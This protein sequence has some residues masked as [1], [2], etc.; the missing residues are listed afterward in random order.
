[1][2]YGNFVAYYRVSTE[3]QGR[4][5]LG[6]DAQR[7]AVIG[8][9]NGGEWKMVAEFVEVESGKRSDNRPQLEAA[10]TAARIRNATLII[11]KLDRLS[12]D[13]HFLLGL[14]K[15]GVDFVAA[16]MPTANKMMVGF[17]ALIAQ[18]EREMISKRTKDAL[19]A[20]KARGKKLGGNPASLKNRDIGS[21]RGNETK[22]AKA[23]GRAVDL[24]PQIDDIRQ[25]GHTSLRQIANALN[26]RGIV[27]PRGGQWTA[28]QVRILLQRLDTAMPAQE[29]A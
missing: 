12:R 15:S 26:E 20:A 4:S 24:R 11:A 14:Q 5:G 23:A 18:H 6:L 28:P 25:S 9:L 3:K 19:A 10:M 8:Y 13:A 27:A 29:A 2:A 17:M 7:A 22:A 1:M 21:K 16:D